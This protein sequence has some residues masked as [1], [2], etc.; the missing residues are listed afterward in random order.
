MNGRRHQAPF[1]PDLGSCIGECEAILERNP[2]SPSV[3]QGG[4]GAL[5]ERAVDGHGLGVVAS[6]PVRVV[7]SDV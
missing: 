4:Q 7:T 1:E 6:I 5:L 3:R 2:C